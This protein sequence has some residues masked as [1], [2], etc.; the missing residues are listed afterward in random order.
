MSSEISISL[1][2][3]N[4][5]TNPKGQDPL[6]GAE[7]SCTLNQ[8]TTVTT[9]SDVCGHLNEDA[10]KGLLLDGEI[11]DNVLMPRTFLCTKSFLDDKDSQSTMAERL[12]W[13][14][15]EHHVGKHV[16]GGDFLWSD[17]AVEYWFQIRPSSASSRYS[18][19]SRD[20]S[21]DD[22]ALS[23]SG[24]TFHYDKDE[25]LHAMT[26]IHIHPHLSTV[27]YLTSAGGPTVVV[28]RKLQGVGG[29]EGEPGGSVRSASVVYPKAQKHLSFDGRKLHGG[30]P[31]M[32]PPNRKWPPPQDEVES[33]YALRGKGDFNAWFKNNVRVTF[34]VNVW[35]WW[36][37]HGVQRMAEPWRAKMSG[38]G[39]VGLEA[40]KEE[41]TNKTM[42]HLKGVQVAKSG[43]EAATTFRYNLT[44]SV[45]DKIELLELVVPT[46]DL[47][48]E[49][50]ALTWDWDDGC[51]VTVEK[52]IQNEKE[53]SSPKRQRVS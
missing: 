21:E 45:S 4:L 53:D 48:G 30:D 6:F 1:N 2:P 46:A 40:A 17:V 50:T 22:K 8:E 41:A 11:C 33:G 18:G 7:G 25:E 24:I 39:G 3:A 35:C 47:N 44:T 51:L 28:D 15:G 49:D 43:S 42:R 16:S 19:A 9:L 23:K 12:A 29:S 38:Y 37:P 10:V 32:L 14:V 20:D 34:L 27:T 26:G 5:P 52:K 13:K 36:K 31:A